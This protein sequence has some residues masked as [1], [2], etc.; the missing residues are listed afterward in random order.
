MSVFVNVVA[1]FALVLD[2]ITEFTVYVRMRLTVQLINSISRVL[3]I[4]LWY[5]NGSVII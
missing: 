5:F 3:Q 2:D 1:W 4:L